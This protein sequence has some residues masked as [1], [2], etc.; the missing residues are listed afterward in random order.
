MKNNKVYMPLDAIERHEDFEII[1][2]DGERFLRFEGPW[3]KES[4]IIRIVSRL[5]AESGKIR[6]DPKTL[7]YYIRLERYEYLFRTIRIF[8]HYYVKGMLWNIKGSLSDLP[9]SF[10]YEGNAQGE[11]GNDVHVRQTKLKGLGDCY[12]IRVD[13][14]NKLRPAACV[15]VAMAI[16]EHYRGLSEGEEPRYESPWQKLKKRIFEKGVTLEELERMEELE[17]A[18]QYA[19]SQMG[20][21][22]KKA[23]KRK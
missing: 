19:L 10:V 20:P 17:E 13:T 23:K 5:G 12:E 6:P 16:K 4:D 7:G 14:V 21:D 22:P 8:R 9:M 1:Y 11:M 2:P 3:E 15:V 18:R